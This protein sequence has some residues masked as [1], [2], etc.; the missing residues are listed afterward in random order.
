MRRKPNLD[1]RIEQCGRLLV[2]DPK[3]ERGEWL[4]GSEWS[5]LCAELGCGKGRFIVESAKSEPESLFVGLEKWDNV[6]VSSLERAATEN[7]PNVRFVC[8]LAEDLTDYFAQGEVSRL[9]V[10]FCDPWPS[11]RH[12]KRRLTGPRFLE[13]YRKVLRPGGELHFKTD[14]LLLFEY[15]LNELECCGFK[16]LDVTRDLHKDGPVGIMTDYEL[17]FYG[18]GFPIYRCLAIL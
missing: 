14:N 1:A 16:L 9:Y 6:L 11:N 18:G 15:S 7:L 13:L 4:K 2:K 8:A 12:I 5:E 10:N 3:A 17:K